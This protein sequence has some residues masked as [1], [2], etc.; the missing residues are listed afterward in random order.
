MC[1]CAE[2]IEFS[3]SFTALSS[4]SFYYFLDLK[5]RGIEVLSPWLQCQILLQQENPSNFELEQA[6]VKY[7]TPTRRF[8]HIVSKKGTAKLKRN[9]V[10]TIWTRRCNPEQTLI[11]YEHS[12]WT[13]W[14]K[15]DG[16]CN[17]STWR[18]EKTFN[19]AFYLS[20]KYPTTWKLSN[21]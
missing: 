12:T 16:L 1:L 20:Y 21:L 10:I 9:A 7:K 14:F 17:G 15:T 6:P 18:M 19:L 4:V 8:S 11:L 2:I 3:P 13:F 5:R